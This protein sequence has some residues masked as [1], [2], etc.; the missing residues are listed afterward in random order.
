MRGRGPLPLAIALLALSS[1]CFTLNDTVTKVLVKDYD[2]TVIIFLRSLIALPILYLL[3]V[4]CGQKRITRSQALWLYALRGG[5]GLCAAWLYILGLRSLSVAE[6]TVLVF[7]SPLLIT[8][9]SV[10]LF[11]ERITLWQWGAALL[12]FL[13]VMVA[14]QPG[15]GALQLSALLV[16]CSAVLYAAIA[17]SARWLPKGESLWQVSFYGALFAGLW[18]TPFALAQPMEMTAGFTTRDLGLFVGAALFSSFGIGMGAMAYRMAAA[19]DLAPFGY[20][21]LL[22]SSLVTLAFWGVVPGPWVLTGMAIVG[23]SGGF[24]LMARPR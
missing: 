3:P 15:S 24:H 6:A 11:R 14:L 7:A 10:L 18:V 5:L 12:S 17:L 2:V 4:I 1:L 16:L 19:S 9:G 13:G 23:L 22:W 20:F 21:G 8:L